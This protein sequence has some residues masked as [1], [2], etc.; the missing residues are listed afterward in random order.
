MPKHRYV[1]FKGNKSF[2]KDCVNNLKLE[3]IDYPKEESQRYN[4]DYK[5]QVQGRLF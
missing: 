1:Y 4:C 5:P 2:K 3:A